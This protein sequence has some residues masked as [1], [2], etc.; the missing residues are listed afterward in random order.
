MR[1]GANQQRF[2]PIVLIK[3]IDIFLFCQGLVSLATWFLPSLKN[4]SLVI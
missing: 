3:R 1:I 2:I 4:L